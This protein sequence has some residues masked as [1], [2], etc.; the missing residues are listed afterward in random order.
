MGKLG[1]L[2]GLRGR[3]RMGRLGQLR[4]QRIDATIVDPTK[5]FYGQRGENLPYS[6]ND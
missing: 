5:N 6:G 4:T 1:L 3:L 2:A